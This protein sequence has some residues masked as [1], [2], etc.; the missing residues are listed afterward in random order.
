MVFKSYL[1]QVDALNSWCLLFGSHVR[2]RQASTAL[3]FKRWGFVN[4]D[5][6]YCE[7]STTSAPAELVFSSVSRR[8]EA[9]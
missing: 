5:K 9:A 1:Y 4:Y 2:S 8:K 7:A 6:R 3:G